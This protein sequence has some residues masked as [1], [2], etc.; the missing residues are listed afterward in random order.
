MP[1]FRQASGPTPL[2]HA[3]V[4][5]LIRVDSVNTL[6]SIKELRKCCVAFSLNNSSFVSASKW[7]NSWVQSNICVTVPFPY[8]STLSRQSFFR[9]GLRN[10]IKKSRCTLEPRKAWPWMSRTSRFGGVTWTSW[11]GL[12]GVHAWSSNVEL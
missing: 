10:E 1:R 9:D 12:V 5:V 2:N 8:R 3:M 6:E 7:L 11:Y 4:V